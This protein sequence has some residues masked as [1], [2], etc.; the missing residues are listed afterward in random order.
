MKEQLAFSQSATFAE[1]W[2][3]GAQVQNTGHNNLAL[4]N[5][6]RMEGCTMGL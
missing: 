1:V 6:S 2:P 3:G 4:S 5:K